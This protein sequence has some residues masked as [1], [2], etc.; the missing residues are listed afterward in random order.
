MKKDSTD[1]AY[2]KSQRREIKKRQAE[3]QSKI[4]KDRKKRKH[5]KERQKIKKETSLK[6]GKR[7]IPW[8]KQVDSATKEAID[9]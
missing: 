1:K 2:T 6:K 8:S 9:K 7:L 4:E 5:R 3:E